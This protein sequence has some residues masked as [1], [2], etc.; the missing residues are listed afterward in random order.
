MPSPGARAPGRRRRSRQAVSDRS[1]GRSSSNARPGF[2]PASLLWHSTAHRSNGYHAFV[3]RAR[4]LALLAVV[5]ALGTSVSLAVAQGPDEDSAPSGQGGE[6]AVLLIM[7]SSLSMREPAGGDRS[8]IEAARGAVREVVEALP[9]GAQ[10]G[11]RVY[12][13]RVDESSRA[14]G[15]RDTRLSVP[16]G[17]LDREGIVSTVDGLAPTGR[18]PIGRSLR[19]AVD[20]FPPDAEPKRIVLVSDGGDNCAPPDPCEAAEEVAQQ[21]V[22]LTIDVVGLQVTDRVRDQLEC[23]ADVGG[24]LYSDATDPEELTEELRALFTRAFR[25]YEPTGTPVQG[26][27]DPTGA[28]AIT[29]GQYLDTITTNEQD[30]YRVRLEPGQRLWATAVALFPDGVEGAGNLELSLLGPDGETLEDAASVVDDRVIDGYD[31]KGLRGGAVGAPEGLPPGDYRLGVSFEATISPRGEIPDTVELPVEL[32]VYVLE[33]GEQPADLG[34]G[35]VLGPGESSGEE[36]DSATDDEDRSG[37][38]DRDSA[39][40]EDDEMLLPGIGLGALGLALGGIAGF[41]GTQR[42]RRM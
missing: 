14:E 6:P 29:E 24:G 5:A 41:T 19:E 40:A 7:D 32:L 28:V 16:V 17:P 39:S 8:R 18:T 2:T 35:R 21:G 22:D 10:V 30:W 31:P 37:A 25:D 34:P 11:L 13:S 9:D 15:C 1:A 20:D 12:G 42:L 4:V 38:G 23:I 3:V 27:P 36:E 26:A 33:E